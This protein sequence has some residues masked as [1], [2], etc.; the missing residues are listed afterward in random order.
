M[1]WMCPIK[2]LTMLKH[3]V[4]LV[5]SC[6]DLCFPPAL[7]WSAEPAPSCWTCTAGR[8]F[9][10]CPASSQS[11]GPTACGNICSKEKASEA[12]TV[13]TVICRVLACSYLVAAYLYN[14]SQCPLVCPRACV[15]LCLQ[16]L[17]SPWS[18][19][20][21]VGPSPNCP[22]DI[23]YGSSNNLQSGEIKIKEV[24]MCAC[25]HVQSSAVCMCAFRTLV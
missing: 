22:K 19:W 10:M 4:W 7:W 8:V 6:C 13:S 1:P 5:T 14:W 16:G 23:G 2:Y 11:C 21:V 3:L 15:H 18:P 9:S 12:L 20:E 17:S 24:C 25:V